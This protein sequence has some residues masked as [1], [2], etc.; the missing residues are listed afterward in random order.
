M[1]RALAQLQPRLRFEFIQVDIDG[2]ADLNARYA[3][4]VPLLLDGNVEICR[5]HV[6]KQALMRR[7]RQVRNAV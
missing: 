6:D 4:C 1:A 3:D 2:D 7:L 5:Y